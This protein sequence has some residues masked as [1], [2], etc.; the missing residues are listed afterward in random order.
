MKTSMGSPDIAFPYSNLPEGIVCFGGHEQW[1]GQMQKKL[2]GVRF[3]PVNYRYDSSIIKRAPCVWIQPC[4][5]SHK[6]YFRIIGDARSAGVERHYFHSL[7]AS[8]SA[9]HLV[10]TMTR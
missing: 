9:R 7:S 2:P 5:L 4:Y 10:L 8:S 3:V 1:I 6:M